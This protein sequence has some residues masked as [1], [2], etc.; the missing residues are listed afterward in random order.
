[1]TDSYNDS[2]FDLLS[3]V[4]KTPV[5]EMLSYNKS[6]K[7]G[8]FDDD[9]D[10]AQLENQLRK[11]FATADKAKQQGGKAK[12]V[13]KKYSE[14]SSVKSSSKKSSDES[15]SSPDSDS[16]TLSKSGGKRE[17]SSDTSDSDEKSG[18]SDSDDTS[19]S[20]QK[21]GC[22]DQEGG[23]K[24]KV[25]KGPKKVPYGFKIFAEISTYVA[26]LG[27]YEK[28]FPKA[29]QLAKTYMDKAK[30][31]SGKNAPYTESEYDAILE[32]AKKL[33]DKDKDHIKKTL[34]K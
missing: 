12:K 31:E 5:S 6:M 29:M 11:V 13:V 30:K 22:G 18:S 20:D 32:K 25:K 9:N 23:E 7:G 34:K 1:M 21:G 27:G 26:Q 8:K 3:I 4:D 17:S 16:D 28:K 10:T 33:A 14:K 2:D 19:S 24:D 15:S